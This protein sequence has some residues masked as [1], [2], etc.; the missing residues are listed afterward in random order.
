[1]VDARAG[2]LG[3][4]VSVCGISLLSILRGWHLMGALFFQENFWCLEDVCVDVKH[5]GCSWVFSGGRWLHGCP[6]ERKPLT[7]EETPCLVFS[8]F[9]TELA[10]FFVITGIGTRK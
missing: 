4:G 6:T 3:W 7:D 8:E 2:P 10:S 1:M 9:T 5:C